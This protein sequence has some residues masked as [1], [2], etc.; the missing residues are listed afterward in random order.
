MRA[1]VFFLAG[2]IVGAV[3][4]EAKIDW[5]PSYSVHAGFAGVARCLS[6]GP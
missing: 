4:V 6:I 2:L 5:R 1:A 3:A